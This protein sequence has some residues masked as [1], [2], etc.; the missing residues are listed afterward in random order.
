MALFRRRY[1]EDEEYE[2]E[3]QTFKKR[4]ITKE[5]KD[6][7]PK[8][9]KMRKEPPKPWG[10]KERLWVLIVLIFTIIASGVLA[11]SARGWKLPGLPRIKLPSLD[12]FKEETIVI[13]K[14]KGRVKDKEESEKI[15]NQ[16]REKTRNLSGVYGL[17]VVNLDNGFSYGVYEDEEFEPASLNKLPVMALMYE[18]DESRNLE[19]GTKYTLKNS[20]KMAG[21]GSLY[22]KPAGH[23][24]TYRDLVRYMGKESDNTA[25]NIAKNILGEEKIKAA[26][27]EI[28]MSNTVILG[29]KQTT[30]PSDIGV[31]FK[32]LLNNEIVSKES[33]DEI[34]SYLTDTFYESWLPAGVPENIR[35]AHKFGRELHVVNDA[36]VVFAKNP[37]VV[38][39]MSKGVVEREADETFPIL[40]TMVYEGQ[41]R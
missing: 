36:G 10:K 8:D 3:E 26:I 39:I 32:K 13:E 7:N 14:D 12:F 4:P 41:T 11:F 18:E 27:K 35:V 17:Y 34:L 29:E 30:S 31:F 28:G 24:L 19:L 6:L 40:S 21:S 2:D 20:D 9:R 23:I 37:Y 25:F 16:F 15:I 5:F 38:V 33:S 1:Q 22:G